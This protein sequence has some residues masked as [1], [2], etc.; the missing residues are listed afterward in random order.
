MSLGDGAQL[1]AEAKKAKHYER[2]LAY[3][4]DGRHQEALIEYKN[5]IHFDPK[6]ANAY[7][8]QASIPL[9]LGGLSDLRKAVEIESSIE[10]PQ[11]KLGE[12]IYSH[13]SQR[14]PKSMQILF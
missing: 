8:Q 1:S 11:L 13:K 9:K 10:E 3:F 12:F 7:H 14:K 2:Q 5:I 4:N 6:D